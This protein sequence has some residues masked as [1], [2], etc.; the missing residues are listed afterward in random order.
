MLNPLQ[1]CHHSACVLARTCTICL[2]DHHADYKGDGDSDH[3]NNNKVLYADILLQ[4]K[5]VRKDKHIL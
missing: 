5:L 2:Y 4:Q 1:E 3:H